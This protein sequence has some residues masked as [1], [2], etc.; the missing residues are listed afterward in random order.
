LRTIPA[1]ALLWS[2]ELAARLRLLQADLADEPAGDREQ[3][4]EGAVERALQNV[5]AE[6]RESFLNAIVAEFPGPEGTPPVQA[7]PE[8]PPAAPRSTDPVALATELAGMLPNLSG[9]QVEAISRQ[10]AQGGLPQQAGTGAPA[11]LPEELLA[12]LEKLAPGK[13]LDQRR[14]L[15]ILDVLL[16]FSLSLDQLVWQVWK[17]VA[18]K[19][20]IHKDG[21]RFGDFRKSLGP[22]L[23][24]DPEVSTEEVRQLLEKSRKL[25][26]GL[27]GAL[28][29][30]GETYADKFLERLSPEAIR[31][32][33][34][35][36]PGV[37]E[38]IERKCWRKY[39][40]VFADLNGPAIEKD[41]L[42]TIRKSTEK[43]ILGA[44]AATA[45]EE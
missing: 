36:E 16:E 2:A 42:N 43:L 30:V 14:A 26:A 4:L 33:A 24:G 28:G 1:E 23:T 18:P 20:V 29:M 12:R 17:A 41:V 31:R 6:L 34:E 45:L 9:D 32:A 38:G 13:P 27:L 5:P 25:V 35:A 15:R 11:A 39:S 40:A 21:G 10:L 3:A 8:Q 44:D 7:I 22:Y 19:S 37:F